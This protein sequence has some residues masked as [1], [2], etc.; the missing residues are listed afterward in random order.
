MFN[1][2]RNQISQPEPTEFPASYS[3]YVQQVQGNDLLLAM[4][5]KMESTVSLLKAIP[6]EKHLFRYQEGKWTIQD[7]IQHIL[8]AERIF[9]YRALRYAR[10]DGT[11]LSSFEEDEYAAVSGA[12]YRPFE[13]L[14][15]EYQA[16][17]KSTISLFNSFSAEMLDSIGCTNQHQMTVRSLGF[18]ILGHECHHI[19]VIR[20][21]YL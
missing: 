12:N 21:R 16:V 1:S 18:V 20:E 11:Q 13:D 6:T 7:I 10:K 4:D 15:F 2:F 3:N 8:D 17:R 19:K 9:A 14:V 5:E